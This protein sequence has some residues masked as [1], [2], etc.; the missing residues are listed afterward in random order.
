[1]QNVVLAQQQYS[2]P[3]P[4]ASELIKYNEACENA[5]DRIITMA[6]KQAKHRQDM[7]KAELESR[8][9]TVKFSMICSTL[10]VIVLSGVI[11]YAVYKEATGTA[12]AACIGAIA[13]VAGI[14]IYHK[15]K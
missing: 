7:E 5:A 3:I 12:I 14:F 10:C 4:P 9:T 1:M 8:L 2:G 13:T 11:I 6:E 15:K